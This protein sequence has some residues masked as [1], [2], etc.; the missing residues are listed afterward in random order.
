M[1]SDEVALAFS[2]KKIQE[3]PETTDHTQYEFWQCS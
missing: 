1:Q 2:N 3:N